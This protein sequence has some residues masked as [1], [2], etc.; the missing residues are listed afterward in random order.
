LQTQFSGGKKL[1][2]NWLIK[3]RSQ[4]QVIGYQG[5][6]FYVYFYAHQYIKTYH[7]IADSWRRPQKK[8]IGLE[9]ASG[10]TVYG[11]AVCLIYILSRRIRK[12]IL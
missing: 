1:R 11:L 4:L 7:I 5:V 3:K 12:I 8:T 9:Q 6:K 2:E 10:E